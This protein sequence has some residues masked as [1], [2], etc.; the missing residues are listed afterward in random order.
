[1]VALGEES[2]LVREEAAMSEVECH[3]VGGDEVGEA[4]FVM[5]K[6]FLLTENRR[7]RLPNKLI[8]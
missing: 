5:A 4:F 7:L 6:G 3:G 1:M 2:P 8:G